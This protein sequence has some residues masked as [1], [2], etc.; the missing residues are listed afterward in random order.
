MNHQV[1][2]FLQY[3]LLER[4]LT[5]NTIQSYRRDLKQ[6][7]NYLSTVEKRQSFENVRRSHIVS[8]LS[9]LKENGKAQTTILRSVSSIRALHQFFLREKITNQDPTIHIDSPQAERRLPTVLTLKEV[10]ALL[11]IPTNDNEYGKRD[12]AML[13]LLYASGL[14]VSEL[15]SLNVADVHLTMGFVRCVGQGNKERIIPLGK[16]A[17]EALTV[18]LEGGRR[19]LLKKNHDDEALFLNHHGKR[20][21]RQGFWKILKKLTRAADINKEL[22]PH[23]LRHSFASHLLENGADLRAVQEMLGHANIST[24]QIYTHLT[25]A[26]LKDIYNSYHP[27]A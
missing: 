1:E 17:T 14:R 3:L 19:K 25:K 6:Y 4:G 23:M 18:Y 20:L 12:K 9:F 24:T 15:T 13:E 16:I 7:I 27:R 21:T 10:E 11:N 22:T 26:R 5:Q 8:Y 2:E